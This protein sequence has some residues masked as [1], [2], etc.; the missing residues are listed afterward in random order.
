MLRYFYHSF[1]CKVH[2]AIN[3]YANFE[4][5]RYKIDEMQKSYILF[6]VI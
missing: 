3:V 1:F 5:N 4:I 6:D 2:G